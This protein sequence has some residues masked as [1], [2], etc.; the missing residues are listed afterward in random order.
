MTV[1]HI[2]CSTPNV[3]GWMAVDVSGKGST[4]RAV[5]DYVGQD[6]C[7][8]L[9]ARP[10]FPLDGGHGAYARPPKKPQLGEAR[11]VSGLGRFTRATVS[12]NDWSNFRSKPI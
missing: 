8:R 6:R 9:V 7:Y 5:F 10:N 11:P 2:G 3:D 12:R 4:A 1:I